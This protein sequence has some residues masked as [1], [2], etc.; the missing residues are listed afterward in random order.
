MTTKYQVLVLNKLPLVVMGRLPFAT[1]AEATAFAREQESDGYITR[2]VTLERARVYSLTE[3]RS[4]RQT[5]L[6]H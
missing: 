4:S 5:A 6:T 1:E 3:F 2:F